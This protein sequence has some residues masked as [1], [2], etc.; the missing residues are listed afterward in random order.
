MKK[1]DT[2]LYLFGL[3]LF[4]L[5]FGFKAQAQMPTVGL[6]GITT[7]QSCPTGLGFYTSDPNHPMTCSQAIVTCPHTAPILLNWGLTNAGGT[8]GT[9]VFFSSA[10]GTDAASEPGEE[11]SFIPAYVAAGYQVVQTAWASPWEIT[12][13]GS[14]S[15]DYNIRNA[16]CRPASVLDYVYQNIYPRSNNSGAGMCAQGSS[17]GG[18]AIIYSLTWF[19]AANSLDKATLMAGP[20]LSDIEQGCEIPNNAAAAMCPTG[21]LGC[22]GWTQGPNGAPIIA[23]LEY[24]QQAD[25]VETWSGGTAIT[26]PAC[27]NNNTATAT[28]QNAAWLHMSIVDTSGYAGT[29]NFNYPQTAMTSWLC[30][31]DVEGTQNNSSSQ[32]MLFYQQ[33]TQPSQVNNYQV[34]AVSLCGGTEGVNSGTPPPN[35]V[36]ILQNAG[37]SPT[38][39]NAIAYDMTNP[40]SAARCLKRH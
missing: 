23:P 30:S 20:P 40:Q 1:M 15:Y 3:S 7:L 26:G 14:T 6:T 17:A 21:Q 10:G 22:N 19:D 5:L 36:T 32:G 24:T 37:L 9:I 39:A 38:G 8:Q 31:S 16:A 2:F 13:N 34:N 11:Q 12:N 35:W 25:L 27:A 18:A 4:V 33:I 28:L 29:P